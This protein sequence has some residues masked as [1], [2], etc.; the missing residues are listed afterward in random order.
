MHKQLAN[1]Y[2]ACA[3]IASDHGHASPQFLICNDC[4]LVKEISVDHH[5]MVRL[6]VKSA[7]FRYKFSAD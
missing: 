7:D 4:D 1:K 2:V 6:L 5:V 3:H